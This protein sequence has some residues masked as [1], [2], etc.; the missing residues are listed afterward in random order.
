MSD[1]VI[2]TTTICL[3]IVVLRILGGWINDKD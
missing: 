3:T 2:I 1:A